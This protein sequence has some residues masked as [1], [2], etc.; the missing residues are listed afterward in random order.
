MRL[1]ALKETIA[2]ISTPIGEGAISVIR[3]SGADALV[4]ADRIFESRRGFKPSQQKSFTSQVGFIVDG[5]GDG[6]VDEV[7]LQV[8]RMPRSYTRED[9]VEISCHGGR[10]VTQRVLG[11]C[12]RAGARAAE[13]GEFTKRAFLNGRIDLVQAEAVLQLIRSKTER[14][15]AIA[16]RELGGSLSGKVRVFRERLVDFLSHAE[17][18]IDFPDQDID[19]LKD[20]EVA[21]GLGVMEEELENLVQGSA[22]GILIRDGV[23]AVLVGKPNV[24]KSS[25]MNA[26]T[27]TNRVI[28]SHR[29]GTTRDIV[30]ELVQI[31]GLPV[32]LVDTAGLGSFQDELEKESTARARERMFQADLVLFVV[33]GSTPLSDAETQ[34]WGE[35]NEHHRFLIINKA[36][37]MN[38][39]FLQRYIAL[40]DGYPCIQTSCVTG[41]GM[42]EV[43]SHLERFIMK[44][45]PEI[46]DE[47]WVSSVR[48]RDLLRRAL[49][50]VR[51]ARD[52]YAQGLSPEFAASDMRLA[53]DALGEITGEVVADEVLDRI[54][55]QFCIG[56]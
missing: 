32:R 42:G 13:P 49:E 11:T 16:Q 43:E 25:L 2:A 14:A 28:V 5:G 50:H 35:L 23:G 46:P 55:S 52:A 10:H 44:D 38:S 54:F 8:M 47:T 33:D 56:K 37:L 26:L 29:P 7:I 48:H 36:D 15:Y 20:R 41:Q 40:G 19:P 9:M 39:G 1:H 4:I 34:V 6:P 3:I 31:R 12:L 51:H 27:G 30:E 17:A 22:S 24:G 45:A 53:L 18:S 21:K